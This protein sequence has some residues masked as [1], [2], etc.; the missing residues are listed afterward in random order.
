[1]HTKSFP[2]RPRP[3]VTLISLLSLY[4]S[5]SFLH[6]EN[7]QLGRGDLGRRNI[8]GPALEGCTFSL[9]MPLALDPLFRF[10]PRLP[11]LFDLSTPCA[12]SLS[13]ALTSRVACFACQPL[14]TSAFPALATFNQLE[15]MMYQPA[16]PEHRFV[17]LQKQSLEEGYRDGYLVEESHLIKE[18][19]HLRSPKG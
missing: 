12:F 19:K 10:W 9:V 13:P 6:P 3:P 17:Y 1:M 5:H 15:A 14:L 8:A 11:S 16:T 2:L 18:I 7:S 4:V